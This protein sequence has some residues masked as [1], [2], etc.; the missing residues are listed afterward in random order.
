M[1]IS[2]L[3][4]K[5]TPSDREIAT[6]VIQ[7]IGIGVSVGTLDYRK[8]YKAA[9]FKYAGNLR[10]LFKTLSRLNDREQKKLY[11]TIANQI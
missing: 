9:M 2:K 7:S 3:Y 11:D 5:L 1:N 8:S 10:L 6:D 4:L